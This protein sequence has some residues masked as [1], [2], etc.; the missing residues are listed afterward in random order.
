MFGGL[1]RTYGLA[2]LD[3]FFVESERLHR[4]E[5]RARPLAIGLGPSRIIAK[6]ASRHAKPASV[7]EVQP[8]EARDFLAPHGVQAVPGIGPVTAR[9]LQA[10]GIG[11]VGQLLTLPRS[12]VHHS[13]GLSL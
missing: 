13:F 12:F 2:D 3:C 5:L 6:M 11:T 4:P 8:D 7:F 9:E 1:N 10:R